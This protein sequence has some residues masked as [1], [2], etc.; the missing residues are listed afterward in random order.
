MPLHA[1]MFGNSVMRATPRCTITLPNAVNETLVSLCSGMAGVRPEEASVR[2]TATLTSKQEQAEQEE[3]YRFAVSVGPLAWVRLWVDDHRL[4]DQWSGPHEPTPTTPS[5]LPNVSL[6]SSRPVFVR[7]DLRPWASWLALNL[8]WRRAGEAAPRTVPDES[9]SPSISSQRVARRALQERAATGWRPWARHSNTAQIHLPQQVGVDFTV[10]DRST[11]RE[12]HDGGLLRPQF[13]SGNPPEPPVPVRMGLHAFDGSYSELSF[14]PFP[15]GTP[16]LDSAAALNLTV[17]SATD[18][19]TTSDR[20][21]V[22]STN[23]SS[24]ANAVAANLSLVFRPAVFWGAH[25]TFTLLGATGFE[26]NA[27]ELGVMTASFSAPPLHT[28]KNTAGAP[29]TALSVPTLE[30]ALT[31]APL[32]LRLSFRPAAPPNV[33]QALALVTRRRTQWLTEMTSAART[34]GGL[35]EAFDALAT[36]IAWNVNFDPRVA[37]T[38]PVSRTFEEA[39]DFLFFDWDMYFLSLMAGT[40]P[41]TNSQAAMDIAISN[42]VEVTQ[43]RS[44]YGFVMN[45]RAAAGSSSSDAN[46]RTEPMV[47]ALVLHRIW[48]DATNGARDELQWVL[49]LRAPTGSEPASRLH[50]VIV[51]Q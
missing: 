41:A 29:V 12:Y 45:K 15:V 4:L 31:E 19:G 9:L 51:P 48:Q 47:G 6:S 21:C 26:I 3:W 28:F 13:P 25:A 24:A 14:V 39:F 5:L 27:G 16:F 42:L 7:L 33:T 50:G 17:V 20:V 22:L 49:E 30:F 8:T 38:A 44:A 2:L 18:D 1:E 40:R 23:A 11:G 10:R 46:D 35:V 43:T 34:C 36:S 32:V 37:V